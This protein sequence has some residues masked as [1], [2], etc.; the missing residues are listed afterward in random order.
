MFN[1][2]EVNVQI[3]TDWTDE[4]IITFMGSTVEKVNYAKCSSSIFLDS[5][6]I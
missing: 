6:K 4:Y 2:V 1:L 5:Y 3:Y